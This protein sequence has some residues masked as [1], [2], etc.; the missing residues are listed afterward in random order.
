MPSAV[1]SD[2]LHLLR[3]EEGQPSDHHTRLRG[4]QVRPE[5]VTRRGFWEHRALS[6]EH[7]GPMGAI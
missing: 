5:R 4:G 2:N 1:P 6:T 3:T 7:G